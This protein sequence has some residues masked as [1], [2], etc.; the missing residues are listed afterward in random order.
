VTTSGSRTR[1]REAIR[2]N[3][4]AP[5]AGLAA[6]L[7]RVNADIHSR[8]GF[9]RQ[10]RGTAR[11]RLRRS[12]IRFRLVWRTLLAALMP[13][14][15]ARFQ[16]SFRSPRTAADGAKGRIARPLQIVSCLLPAASRDRW[17]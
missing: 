12:V 3:L 14:P 8:Y 7:R 11:L 15:A 1:R 2:T 9:D 16:V 10:G 13:A 5:L 6:D 17:A 4:R